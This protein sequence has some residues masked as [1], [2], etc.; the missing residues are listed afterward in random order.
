[1]N[2]FRFSLLCCLVLLATA[3][4]SAQDALAV[5]EPAPAAAPSAF[6]AMTATTAPAPVRNRMLPELPAAAGSFADFLATNVA[7]PELAAEYGIEGTVVVRVQVAADGTPTA[8]GLARSVSA[9]LDEAALAAAA[10]LPRF[11]PAVVN[12]QPVARTLMV[13]FKFSLR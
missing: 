5:A 1:M 10:R 13:P 6:S 7:Y 4:V 3:A 2:F 9:P 12:G 8:D 11:L